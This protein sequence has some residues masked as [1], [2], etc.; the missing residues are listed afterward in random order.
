MFS[1]P[2]DIELLAQRCAQYGC[3]VAVAPFPDRPVDIRSGFHMLGPVGLVHSRTSPLNVSRSAAHVAHDDREFFLLSLPLRGMLD[4]M[5]GRRQ[6][7]IGQDE[8]VLIAGHE[9]YRLNHAE[10][11]IL[12]TYTLALPAAAMRA[13]LP[14]IGERL[15]QAL[16][17]SQAALRLLRDYLAALAAPFDPLLAETAG[18]H[19][20][21]LAV[22][23]LARQD[24]AD[25][26]PSAV[27]AARLARLNQLL[28]RHA[29]EAGLTLNDLAG[30]MALSPRSVQV[31]FAA[32][33]T[34]FS[35]RLRQVRVRRAERLLAE[36]QAMTITDIA[37]ACGF[38]DLSTFNRNFRAVTGFRPSEVR[39]RSR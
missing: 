28:E 36:A 39:A 31:L 7:R 33:D 35:A 37:Y 19:V 11:A 2:A 29:S 12:E 32:M 8:A 24:V 38:A 9:P 23:A 10:G 20:I 13:R 3:T 21:D 4:L 15:G 14:A 30:A 34:S 16:D 5:Q 17:G 18:A 1:R 6:S 25:A 26:S 22:L 27:R